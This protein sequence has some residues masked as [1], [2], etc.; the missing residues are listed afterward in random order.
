MHGGTT[1][2]S[3]PMHGHGH[4]EGLSR[5]SRRGRPPRAACTG[6]VHGRAREPPATRRC[7]EGRRAGG[8]CGTAPWPRAGDG[9]AQPPF[10][11]SY[12]R[13]QRPPALKVHIVHSRRRPVYRRRVVAGRPSV[14]WPLRSA[15]RAWAGSPPRA[16][17]LDAAPHGAPGVG[18]VSPRMSRYRPLA[19]TRCLW[20]NR[21]ARDSI[22]HVAR[23]VMIEKRML[24]Y[25]FDQ[26]EGDPH[27][28]ILI[29][30]DPVPGRSRV[31]L[32]GVTPLA[33][34]M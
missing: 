1:T 13:G 2:R 7:P 33:D 18:G 25:I 24:E 26:C 31:R 15:E 17:P 10:P 8:A 19:P 21:L 23:G 30:N 34:I 12:A 20:P 6:P 32:N 14:R 28:F 22:G 3:D 16:A 27:T 5:G 11:P 9:T 4:S 29:E